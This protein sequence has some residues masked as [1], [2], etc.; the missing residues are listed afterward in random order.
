MNYFYNTIT[1]L[2]FRPEIKTS[3]TVS[4]NG[5]LSPG[6]HAQNTHAGQGNIQAIHTG[7]AGQNKTSSHPPQ[8]SVLMSDYIA[9]IAPN[10]YRNS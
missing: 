9:A 8:I 5:V 6:N 3:T 4:G 7:E 10:S 2:Q 1:A